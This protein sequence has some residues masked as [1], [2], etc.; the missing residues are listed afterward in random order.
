VFANWTVGGAITQT[1]A[2]PAAASTITAN[3]DTEYLL[4]LEPSPASGGV[5]TTSPT[6][7]DGFYAAGTAVQVRAVPNSG[8]EFGGFL[9]SLNGLVNPQT[10]TMNAIRT[11]RIN[12]NGILPK[13]EDLLV[14]K[15]G[16]QGQF[17][18]VDLKFTN[19]GGVANDFRI[20]KVELIV[21][22]NTTLFTPLPLVVGN[23]PANGG[24]ATPRLLFDVNILDDRFGIILYFSAQTL[25][26]QT[27]NYVLGALVVR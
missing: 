23:V 21:R 13:F 19:K 4:T 25:S 16:N 10:V 9:G 18:F 1:I 15:V 8:F 11:V 14:E 5:V 7:A 17:V 27:V 24:T 22:G 26:G 3:F 6:S 20:N 12:F 2:A